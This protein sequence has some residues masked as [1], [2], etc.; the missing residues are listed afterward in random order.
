MTQTDHGSAYEFDWIDALLRAWKIGFPPAAATRAR[1]SLCWIC[2][3]SCVI[4]T[5]SVT[6]KAWA[7]RLCFKADDATLDQRA[8]LPPLCAGPSSASP[9]SEEPIVLH[10]SV[11]NGDRL[12][13]P[14]SVAF[15]ISQSE[16]PPFKRPHATIS[17][18]AGPDHGSCTTCPTATT[19][20]AVFLY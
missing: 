11:S 5:P 10:R 2:S 3:R 4:L 17:A 14:S 20:K 15:S 16:R 18:S 7:R 1:Q 9:F 8:A 12:W 19:C 13:A 6:F